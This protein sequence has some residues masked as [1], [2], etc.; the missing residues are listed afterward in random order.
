MARWNGINFVGSVFDRGE[1][2]T[3]DTG[4][5]EPEVEANVGQFVQLKIINGTEYMVYYDAA[6]G[7]LK[8]S[9]GGDIHVVDSEG[10]VGLWPDLQVKDGQIH[11]MYQDKGQQRL[12]YARGVPGEWT[13]IEVD[14][15]PY[16]GADTATYFE[17][18]ELRVVY[19]EGRY[20]DLKQAQYA[21]AAGAWSNRVISS[22]GAVGFHNEVV[23]IGGNNFVA[24]YNF[25]S[26]SVH[27]AKLD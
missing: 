6:H 9:I 10:D 12:K 24:C 2:V 26:R 23:K 21:P 18:D 20:N 27:F 13:I 17:G 1:P 8:L 14:R 16:T 19:F 22:E 4:S 15:A 3:G 11:I 7:D 5:S 25:T